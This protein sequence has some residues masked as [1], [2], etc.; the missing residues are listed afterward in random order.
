MSWSIQS[1]K[2]CYLLLSCVELGRC[3][4]SEKKPGGVKP[5]LKFFTMYNDVIFLCKLVMVCWG[6][7]RLACKKCSF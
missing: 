2:L 7:F 3:A 6:F 5:D 4:P 1:T